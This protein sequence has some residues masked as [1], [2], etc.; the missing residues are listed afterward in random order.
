M[1]TPC[2][3]PATPLR[4]ARGRVCALLALAGVL[5]AGN[6]IAQNDTAAERPAGARD[7][8]NA[9]TARLNDGKLREAEELLRDATARNDDTVSPA[10]LF[11][12]GHVRATLGNDELRRIT[13][14]AQLQQMS[15]RAG[16]DAQSVAQAARRALAEDDIAAILQAYRRG[17]AARKELRTTAQAVRAA[18]EKFG[19]VLSTWQR[20]AGDFRSAHELQPADTNSSFNASVMDRRIAA[21]VDSIKEQQAALM[22]AAEAGQQLNDLMKELRKRLPKNAG[23]SGEED[24]DED[25]PGNPE[26]K[27]DDDRRGPRPAI[28]QEEAARLLQ[29]LQ[30][31]SQRTLPVRDATAMPPRRTGGDW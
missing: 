17:T 3:R 18:L 9:G 2:H 8:Y 6:G 23:N 1:L 21:L 16:R 5:T 7:L 28:S 30:L 4:T 11:N 29:G 27:P 25:D 14:P 20:S 22:A 15:D 13:S 12:L 26:S 19:G 10:A 24:E 31:D